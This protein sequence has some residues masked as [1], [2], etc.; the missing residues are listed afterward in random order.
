M[1]TKFTPK[2]KKITGTKKN[3]KITWVNKSGWKSALTVNAGNGNDVINFK[4]SKYKNNKLNGGNGNDAVYGGTNIDIIHGNAGKDKL[5]GYNG[6]DK[7]YGDAGN[8]SIWGG[9]GNDYIDGGADKDKLYGEAGNDIIKG[10]KGNDTLDG[11]DGNDKLYG[12]AGNDSIIG[13][14]GNDS[15]W[16]GAGNDTINAGAGKNTIYFNKGDG[17][18]TVLAGGGEDTLVFASTDISTTWSGNDLIIK[19]P[20]KEGNIVSLKD[21]ASGDHSV[22]WITVGKETFR[23]DKF[24]EKN[25]INNPNAKSEV[26]SLSV[27]NGTSK[28][29]YI[30]ISN[31]EYG[32]YGPNTSVNAG[33]GDDEIHITAK[34]FY[35]RTGFYKELCGTIVDT[36]KGDD[37]IYL[38]NGALAQ[39]MLQKGNGNDI[40]YGAGM[41]TGYKGTGGYM[42]S[43]GYV[44][45][46]SGGYYVSSGLFNQVVLDESKAKGLL[47]RKAGTREYILGEKDDNDLIIKLTNGETV[48]IKE[49]YICD[50]QNSAVFC[51][52]SMGDTMPISALLTDKAITEI[53]LN[54]KN[55]K[56]SYTGSEGGVVIS[57]AEKA[58]YNVTLN[59]TSKNEVYL[60]ADAK[61]KH[62]INLGD[63]NA[64][65]IYIQKA[66]PNHNTETY[67]EYIDSLSINGDVELKINE[68]NLNTIR[69]A[70]K[71]NTDI[72][73]GDGS[74]NSFEIYGN[75]N[76]I[77]VGNGKWNYI[78]ITGA[79]TNTVK[80]GAGIN[81]IFIYDMGDNKSVNTINSYG[82]DYIQTYGQTSVNLYGEDTSKKI[83]V[84]GET[85]QEG[86]NKSVV[87]VDV[88]NAIN[89]LNIELADWF[90]YR[91]NKYFFSILDGN[92]VSVSS[93]DENGNY[94]NQE[95]II[96]NGYISDTNQ[97]ANF[98][99][100]KDGVKVLSYANRSNIK[101]NFDG[102]A[103]LY[104]IGTMS[105][106]HYDFDWNSDGFNFEGNEL[107]IMGTD[108]PE[109][110]EII[111]SKTGTSTIYAKT[112][113]NQL[114]LWGNDTAYLSNTTDTDKIKL[115]A[116][117][118]TDSCKKLVVSEGSKAEIDGFMNMET[119]DV[120]NSE[121][122]FKD[123]NLKNGDIMVHVE[124]DWDKYGESGFQELHLV[125]R[126]HETDIK[127]TG[128]YDRYDEE[129]DYYYQF[130]GELA[131]GA[132]AK[133]LVTD[134]SGFSADLYQGKYF[135]NYI[136]M[137]KDANKS[138]SDYGEIEYEFLTDE[139]YGYKY[140]SNDW[141]FD[142]SSNSD[143]YNLSGWEYLPGATDK[144]SHIQNIQRIDIYDQGGYDS[145]EL[146]YDFWSANNE[147]DE[148]DSDSWST[149][150]DVKITR[151]QYGEMMDYN[152]SDLYFSGDMSSL[153]DTDKTN[154]SYLC[155]H[156]YFGVGRIESIKAK[157]TAIINPKD[158]WVSNDKVMGLVQDVASWIGENT[159]Y[160][161][162]SEVIAKGTSTQK[163][164]LQAM[165]AN[166]D[167]TVDYNP[168]MA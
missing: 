141:M 75:E 59:E 76:N 17:A 93:L 128:L 61:T 18:D 120:T 168:N 11:G 155:I 73:A 142:G 100:E 9:K 102:M 140:G 38:H 15:I 108:D 23:M 2:K 109:G 122:V 35:E 147:V 66:E 34:N 57:G 44:Y 164:Y 90:D 157:D 127:V 81:N 138:T 121:I 88:H 149:F 42:G 92:N 46:G 36:G 54:S 29:D 134:S 129:G 24:I 154:D 111:T 7:I 166:T 107:I 114:D 70:T 125:T 49:Y 50:S 74:S 123:A 64:N 37:T 20:I 31:E 89:Q 95:L 79:K 85:Q 124:F 3:D 148:Y 112:G 131:N 19:T 78:D 150:I 71:G 82:N 139:H 84:G 165:F 161:S 22:K 99:K 119:W 146:G 126:G 1:A 145:L 159:S 162:V 87:T 14:K 133:F 63:G 105:S 68:G 16:G 39:V 53:K 130:D 30:V 52:N 80:T 143:I 117:G 115:N 152:A 4:K 77:T 41:Y 106:N 6:N 58:D 43:G 137:E 94:T 118:A 12:D 32:K 153:F 26:G 67:S 5:Y 156:D 21:Y 62:T 40:I 151:N 69:I 45:G 132:T 113:A 83:F 65:S 116:E 60:T 8:D 48:T 158:V 47:I 160:S 55:N 97:F 135:R 136:D 13:G 110:N 98:L 10:G 163:N 33:K 72:T 27:Y 86:V 104:D 101:F 144:S 103:Q 28:P 51:T 25:Y 91:N 96:K 56:Y 167:V